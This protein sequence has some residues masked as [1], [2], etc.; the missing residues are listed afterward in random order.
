MALSNLGKRPIGS[1]RKVLGEIEDEVTWSDV[2]RQADSADE[3]AA[4]DLYKT[5]LDEALELDF[6]GWKGAIGDRLY[7]P[8]SAFGDGAQPSA[9]EIDD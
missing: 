5:E 8:R 7:S 1:V 3:R 6:D 9:L 2:Y 4:I